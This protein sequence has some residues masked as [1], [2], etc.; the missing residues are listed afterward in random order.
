MRGVLKKI[1]TLIRL[2]KLDLDEKRRALRG[3]EEKL[4]QLKDKKTR[5]EQ[6]LLAE[7][8]A[9]SE[10]PVASFTYSG[11]AEKFKKRRAQLEEETAD[12]KIEIEK[13]EIMVQIAF[14]ELKKYEITA[15]RQEKREKYE[16]GVK[17]QIELDE[18]GLTAFE[19]KNS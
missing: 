7:Q 12:V 14:Q 9:A 16:A 1:G 18:A 5:L 4:Q 3:L 15:E 13:A 2:Y 6:E 8:K 10:S 17:E 11:Y 19:R